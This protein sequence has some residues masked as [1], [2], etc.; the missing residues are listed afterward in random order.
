MSNISGHDPEAVHKIR[1]GH[2]SSVETDL[3]RAKVDPDY[4]ADR[5]ARLGNAACALMEMYSFFRC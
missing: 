3:E 4:A 2:Y 1:D 5:H